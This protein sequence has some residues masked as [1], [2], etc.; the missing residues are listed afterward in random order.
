LSSRLRT[1]KVI[2]LVFIISVHLPFYV[3]N[4]TIRMKFIN[5]IIRPIK[6]LD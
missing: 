4:D 1:N 2:I 5:I 3:S 6:S